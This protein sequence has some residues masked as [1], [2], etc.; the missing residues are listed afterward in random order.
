[1]GGKFGEYMYPYDW[2]PPLFTW[3][4]HSI[5]TQLFSNI[6]YK[7]KKNNNRTWNM[8]ENNIQIVEDSKLQ[9]LLLDNI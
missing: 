4:H 2:V 9:P 8:D 7:I 3:N 6:K 1:M 5:I